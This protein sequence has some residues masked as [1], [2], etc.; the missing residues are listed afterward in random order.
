VVVPPAGYLRALRQIADEKGLLLMFD[1]VQ[2]GVGRTG[3]LFAHQESG[4]LPDVMTLGKGLGGGVPLAA[5][6]STEQASCFAPGEQG[7]T[8]NGNPLCTA[9]GRAV[10]GVVRGEGFLSR[11]TSRGAF[12]RS[13]LERLGPEHGITG[14]RGRGLL[15]AADLSTPCGEQVRDRAF[16]LGL[17]VNSPRPSMLRFMPALD[18]TEDAISEMLGLLGRALA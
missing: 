9:A 5:L 16:E 13:G 11:V 17:L 15:I 6:L 2:T 8:F 12:L 4:V 7:G 14:V 3:H 10:L 1:E 18:V